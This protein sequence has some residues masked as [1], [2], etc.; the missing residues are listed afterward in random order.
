MWRTRL[1][2]V[3]IYFHMRRNWLDLITCCDRGEKAFKITALGRCNQHGISYLIINNVLYKMCFW[4]IH[5]VYF[6]TIITCYLRVLIEIVNRGCGKA[7]ID[8]LTPLKVHGRLRWLINKVRLWSGQCL[9]WCLAIEGASLITSE[10][11][12]PIL[13]R[14]L[15]TNSK[16]IN[17]PCNSRLFSLLLVRRF[18]PLNSKKFPIIRMLIW[19]VLFFLQRILQS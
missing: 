13:H 2:A 11:S 12:E 9:I 7:A 19:S 17:I 14:Y 18:E 10:N 1:V 6:Y 5:F 15:L 3:F 4:Y 8:I 16:L